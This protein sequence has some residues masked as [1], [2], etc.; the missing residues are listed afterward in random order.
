MTNFKKHLKVH[1][2][3]PE[4]LAAECTKAASIL[5][6]FIKGKNQVDLALIPPKILNNAKGVAVITIL[7]GTSL[8]LFAADSTF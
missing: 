2:P 7:K 4:N 3:L 1:N 8:C 6:H 5:T